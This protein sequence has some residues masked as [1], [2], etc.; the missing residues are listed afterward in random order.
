MQLAEP[1]QRPALKDQLGAATRVQQVG[2]RCPYNALLQRRVFPYYLHHPDAVPGNAAFRVSLAEGRRI[3]AEL[4][5]RVSGI[6][7]PTYVLDPPD[8]SGKVAISPDPA[9]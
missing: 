9:G 8:G 6:G 2:R 3:Y 1:T 5:R 7:L 4:R